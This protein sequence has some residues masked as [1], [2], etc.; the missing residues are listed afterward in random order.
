MIHNMHHTN[1]VTHVPI[2]ITEMPFLSP[3]TRHSHKCN[4][5][6]F[7]PSISPLPSTEPIILSIAMWEMDGKFQP[8]DTWQLEMNAYHPKLKML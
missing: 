5:F 7:F 6:Y 1:N 4:I 3:H 2:E 8:H